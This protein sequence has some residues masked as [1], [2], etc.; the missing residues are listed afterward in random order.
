MAF[1]LWARLAL[2]AALGTLIAGYVWAGLTE[3][4]E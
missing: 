4:D 3:R 1:L 2:L